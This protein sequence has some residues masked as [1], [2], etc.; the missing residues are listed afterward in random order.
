MN[1]V[2]LVGR[3][4][5]DPEVRHSQGANPMAVAR[6][7]LAVDRPKRKD[8]E[9]N[10]DFIRVVAFDKRGEF[11]EKYLKK[12]TKII[13][14]G[15]IQTGSYQD[16]DGKTVYTTDVVAEEQEFAES[17]KDAAPAAAAASA[18]PEE[19][20]DFGGFMDIPD[21]DEDMPFN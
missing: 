3:L 10:A 11:A 9:S 4:T 1:N 14:R 19:T 15:R 21:D 5:A 12:G 17:K 18:T 16:K 20:P 7:T 2:I 6:Y 8:G 13:L